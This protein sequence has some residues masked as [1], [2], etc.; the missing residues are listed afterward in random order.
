M[1]TVQINKT[2]YAKIVDAAVESFTA[3]CRAET[4]WEVQ[5]AAEQPAADSAGVLVPPGLEHGVTR[6]NGTGHGWGKLPD[7]APIETAN[8]VVI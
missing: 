8:V 7:S 3:Q 2:A 1:S 6:A 5:F 4:L